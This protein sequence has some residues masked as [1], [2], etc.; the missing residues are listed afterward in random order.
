MI[1]NLK[2][3]RHSFTQEERVKG[4]KK[5]TDKKVFRSQTNALKKGKIENKLKPCDSCLIPACPKYKK[6]GYCSRFN[7]KLVR[8]VMYK[9]NLSSVREFDEYVFRFLERASY[10]TCSDSYEEMKSFLDDLIEF[11][12]FRNESLK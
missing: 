1:D 4:G 8:L 9:K 2:G 3:K 10:S 12:E 7:T 5:I 6:D 11:Q